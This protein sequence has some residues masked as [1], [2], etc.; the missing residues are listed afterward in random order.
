VVCADSAFASVAT[1]T[2]LLREHGMYFMGLVKTAHARFP[3]KYFSDVVTAERGASIILT[4]TVTGGEQDVDVDATLWDD[5]GMYGG[6]VTGKRKMLVATCGV[7][8]AGTPHRKKRFTRGPD[9][10]TVTTFKEVKRPK[11]VEEYFGAAATID[12]HN[13]HRQS[14]LALEEA[15]RTTTW[16]HR[17]FATIVGVT[18]TDAYLAYNRWEHP[19]RRLTHRQF[20]ESVAIGLMRYEEEDEEEGG[21]GGAPGEGGPVHT[22]VALQSLPQYD[23]TS[24]GG[25][26]K[27]A[28]RQCTVCKAKKASYTCTS[29]SIVGRIIILCG[30]RSGRQCI[31]IH[32]QV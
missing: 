5:T 1:A 27:R 28:L 2:A 6:K 25:K 14:A 9:G 7:T 32:T 16:W 20:T 22:V 3:K 23:G 13:H 10:E 24:A 30:P 26:R 11:N 12:V 21:A 29:C 19:E 17:V 4:T 15:W 8:T 18:E 31:S